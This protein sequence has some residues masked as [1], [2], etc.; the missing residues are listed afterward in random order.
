LIKGYHRDVAHIN[1]EMV[2]Q[3]R[4]GPYEDQTQEVQQAFLFCMLTLLPCINS[5]WQR[6]EARLNNLVSEKTTTSDEALL[7]WYL[8]CY[9]DRW[10]EQF[11][12]EVQQQLDVTAQPLPKRNK[13]TGKHFARIYFYKFLAME[14]KIVEAR[15]STE[16]GPKNTGYGWD[17]AVK[18]EAE[19][20]HQAKKLEKHGPGLEELLPGVDTAPKH[21]YT[22]VCFEDYVIAP[23]VLGE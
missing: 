19:R 12:Q 23:F 14:K 21:N 16:S 6:N 1:E 15:D 17:Q 7:Y 10:V 8:T 5:E 2:T 18:A 22:N 20:L 9:E 11:D 13:A 3:F 4:S